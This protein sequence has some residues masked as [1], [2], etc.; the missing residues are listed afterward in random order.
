MGTFRRPFERAIRF[1]HL[2][3]WF[4]LL[5]LCVLVGIVSGIGAFAFDR[6]LRFL[7]SMLLDDW[8]FKEGR[9]Q[10]VALVGV[11]ALGGALVGALGM[12]LAPEATGHGTDS[13]IRAFH[14]N[15]GEIRARIPIVKGVLSIL[16]I[17]SG[18]SAGKEGPIVQIGAGFGSTLA[19]MLKLSIKDRRILMLSGVAGGIGAIFKAPLG[20]ALFAAEFLYRDPDFEHD[21]VIP[22]VISSVTAYSI[23]TAIDG[24]HNRIF[25]FVGQDNRPLP[26][27]SYPSDGGNAFGELIH[28][29]IL[30]LLCA[31]VAYLFVKGLKLIEH[32]VFKPLPI[33][34]FLKP[35]LG[36]AMLGGLALL[37][38]LTISRVDTPANQ[39]LGASEPSH[40]MGQGYGYLQKI[41]NSAEDPTH[42]DHWV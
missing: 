25:Q 16:T 4:R 17:G 1:F 31:T 13:V 35:A 42:V 21:A 5:L 28:Y 15:K 22:G 6:T 27:I 33:P 37:L 39:V 19:T 29:A 38:M 12:W 40:I 18:G 24:N 3:S 10:Y 26:P 20:G 36:G 14:R 41:I 23:F 8:L 9:W 7:Q 30:S 34:K 32:Y 2:E 11:P